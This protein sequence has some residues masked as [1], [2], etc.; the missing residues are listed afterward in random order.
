[1]T[2]PLQILLYF[3]TLLLFTV[4]SYAQFP[5]NESFRNSTASGISFGGT[6]SAFLTAS[7]SS[8]AG[9]T[10]IDPNGSGFLRLTN[11]SQDQKGYAY[12]ASNFPSSNGLKVEF[13]YYI[14]GG[15]GA[16]GI[17]FFL[18]DATASPF[19]IGGFGGSLGYAQIT[20]TTPISPG[21]SKGYLAIGL[22]EFGNFS[23]PNEG[24]QG[25]TTQV[26]GSITLRG[27][28]DGNSLTPDNYRFLISQQTDL[29]GVSLVGDGTKRETDPTQSGYRKVAMELIPNPAG[30]YNINVRITKGGTPQ[31]SYVIID[32][33]YYPDVAP[34]NLRYG[35]ASS[36]GDQTNFHEIR[37]VAIDL[38][39]PLP[40]ANPD[41]QNICLGNT[42][43]IDV[44][45]NDNTSGLNTTI[46][47]A[48]VDLDPSTAGIQNT[49]TLAGKGT[50][51]V[52]TSGIVQFV[53]E[54]GFIG[55]A[56]TPYT[57]RDTDGAISSTG[58][59]TLNY[60]APPTG[61]S[62]GSDQ[63]VT[64]TTPTGNYMLQGSNPGANSGLWTQISGP[65]T[66]QFASTL[67]YNSIVSNLTGGIY[68]F[69]WTVTSP[70]GCPVFDDV[71]ITVNHP[72]VANNDIINT[73]LNTP[74][75]IA[76]I[77]NDTDA[78]TNATINKGSISVKSG[79]TNGSLSI[80]NSTGAVTYT[81]NNG[82]S[83]NDTFTYTIKD[84]YGAESNIATVTLAV[85]VKPAGVNDVASTLTNVAV[86]IP[87]IDNDPGKSGS[88]V[89]RNTEPANGTYVINPAG[90]V[91]Y[92]PNP[93]FSGKDTFT[94]KLRNNGVDSDPIQVTVNVKPVGT[95]DNGSTL[96]NIPVTTPVKDNDLSKNGTVILINNSPSNG[97]VAINGESIVY[98]PNAGYSGKD[99]YSYIL[100]TADG[101]DSDPILVSLNVRPVGSADNVVTPF[102]RPVTI[103]VKN[104]DLSKT[105]TTVVPVAN[106][107]HGTYTVDAGNNVVYTPVT[108]YSGSDTFTYLLRTADG[109]SSDPITV[110]V[111]ISPQPVAPDVTVGTPS[112]KPI[113][114]TVPVP[115]GG[116]VII[117]EQPEHG[118]I[119]VDPITG[120]IRYT[121]DP[122]YSGPDD[123]T[124]VIR[125]EFGN[126]ST[127]GKITVT[128]SLQ[129]KI[130]LAKKMTSLKKNIDGSFNITYKFTLVNAGDYVVEKLSLTDDLGITFKDA[131]ITKVGL[132]A[133]GT[134]TV[135]PN[136]DGKS[137]KDLL[138]SSSAIRQKSKE[139]VTLEIKVFLNLTEGVF[140]NTAI[141]EGYSAN[142]GTTRTTDVSTDAENPDPLVA[143]D[144]SPNDPTPVNLVRSDIFIPGGF[145]PNNDGIND[146]FVIENTLGKQIS[147]EVYNRW[148]NRIYRSSKYENNWAGKTTEGIHI[149]DDVPAGTYYYII[150]VDNK[151]KRVGYITI[152]R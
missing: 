79:P 72:P 37:N 123:F 93:G 140:L 15:T 8:S 85:N 136:Y 100:R 39:N 40:L 67:F 134:L 91:T 18:F 32:N 151:D 90:T 112:D 10:P 53:P 99:A 27:R 75:S 107:L 121:P 130:G 23:N 152:N 122:N 47:K 82:F 2:K 144:F 108:G 150:K 117:K 68:T 77:D 105:G 132:S 28:G 66:A 120:E 14:Y 98:T 114:I 56:T 11:A 3:L 111:T 113:L 6:P 21:V 97:S 29:K 26:P 51:S 119:T 59:I 52:N 63:L 84:I 31:V 62:A 74:V 143:G 94:Y 147:L 124:Y 58:S 7:G 129:V 133:T 41:I 106:P 127:P 80:N 12:S 13:E 86:T 55:T 137:V 126:E 87:V 1:M 102:N 9:G 44:T 92:T 45:A 135:N 25:G 48:S 81:P 34:A 35:F 138:S 116:T 109:L 131:T 96:T 20:T 49:L 110:N 71:Q 139:S 141:V 19:N 43:S 146:F 54:P 95:P 115:P 36:T 128:I 30:G 78:E 42:A 61:T 104:N 142:D 65:N 103:V 83:G 57:F 4:E 22:D 16:D 70:G 24:R 88:S 148:G 50:F 69:R 145:S 118:T 17:S 76:I 5:Y 125:D 149:G 60:S 64:I 33:Y 73:P 101:L 38:Y 89:I 46:N